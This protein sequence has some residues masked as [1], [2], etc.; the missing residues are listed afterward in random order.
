MSGN[1]KNKWQRFCLAGLL[2]LAGT[3]GIHASTDG[4]P[5]ETSNRAGLAVE[6]EIPRI[7]IGNAYLPAGQ[8]VL[9]RIDQLLRLSAP[10]W[11]FGN[12]DDLG[13]IRITTAQNEKIVAIPVGRLQI[14]PERQDGFQAYG[15]GLY[16]VVTDHIVT[17]FN[18]SLD[19]LAGFISALQALDAQ[20]TVRMN[21]EGNLQIGLGGLTYL[22]QAAWSLL[23]VS[24]G[25]EHGFSHDGNTLWW[26]TGSGRQALF[27]VSAS[28]ERLVTVARKLDRAALAQGTHQGQVRLLLDGQV[29][30]LR[31]FWELQPTPT[32]HANDDFWVE[33][34]VV[35]LN[36][37]NGSSQGFTV[38]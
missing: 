38:E 5:T 31:P 11:N 30:L 19:D 3:G 16:Q 28:L 7:D 13:A 9:L 33:N 20:A 26:T 2:L 34:G 37:L 22:V 10:D 27:P 29:Y 4:E 6:A 25:Q 14:D 35:Y 15:N 12:Q 23:P 8:N 17:G 32:Q 21:S 24:T 18:A 36:Y 1:R